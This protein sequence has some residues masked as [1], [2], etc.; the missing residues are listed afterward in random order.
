MLPLSKTK[1]DPNSAMTRSAGNEKIFPSIPAW[2]RAVDCEVGNASPS[3]SWMAIDSRSTQQPSAANLLLK[4]I[5]AGEICD[6]HLFQPILKMAQIGK[7]CC[8]PLY[9]TLGFTFPTD[10]AFLW[11][12]L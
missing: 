6:L 5:F 12:A 9:F 3:R 11:R 7:S 2:T 4:E 1:I 10:L 8:P